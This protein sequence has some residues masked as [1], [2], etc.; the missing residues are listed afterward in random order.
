MRSVLY[1]I[2]EYIETRN[3]SKFE[4]I[5]LTVTRVQTSLVRINEVFRNEHQY[6]AQGQQ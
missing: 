2:I 5:I 4:N 1:W 6:R 3:S